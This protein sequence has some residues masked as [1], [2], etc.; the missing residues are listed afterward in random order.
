MTVTAP[1][2]AGTF[3][4]GFWTC[5][6]L[7]A[8]HLYPALWHATTAL[9]AMHR[10][11]IA[12]S[13]PCLP[14][15]STNDEEMQFSL[16]QFNTSIKYLV[17]PLSGQEPTHVD[18]VVM[19]TA[20]ILSTCLCSL[21]GHQMQALVHIRNGLKL[22]HE[23]KVWETRPGL[24][25]NPISVDVLSTMLTR[26]DTQARTLQ[27]VF[28]MSTWDQKPL[29]FA[30][31]T[32]PIESVAEAY[33]DLEALFNGLLQVIQRKDIMTPEQA[34]AVLEERLMYSRHFDIWDTKFAEYRATTEETKQD[35]AIAKLRILRLLADI[36]L[37]F[38]PTRDELGYD[39]FQNHFIR[40]VDLSAQILETRNAASEHNIQTQDIA[41]PDRGNSPATGRIPR[42][43]PFFSL[44]AGVAEPLYVV[45]SRCRDPT[46]RRR[47][48]H[49]L[50]SHPSRE[51][52]WESTLGA[53]IAEA[54]MI[55]EEEIAF[56][57][58]WAVSGIIDGGCTACLTTVGNPICID[59]RIRE[60]DLFLVGDER[61]ARVGLKTVEESRLSMPGAEILI[62]W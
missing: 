34:A 36:L 4:F 32:A 29:I 24:P 28:S 14:R 62:E 56:G 50:R 26:L 60:V 8:S 31:K 49:L 37:K 47:A 38:D 6:L 5:K 35:N 40:I 11:Y 53:K 30:E 23:W 1:E 43:R 22:F 55:I 45:A 51:G 58:Q 21:Q 41:T 27:D 7:Q 10:R 18:K 3:D 42:D 59:H 48:L 9:G 13:P 33:M 25:G 2:L 44:E 12:G 15:T 16:R 39:D 20:C 54:G 57:P 17:Q 61:H 52:I 19:L 46:L